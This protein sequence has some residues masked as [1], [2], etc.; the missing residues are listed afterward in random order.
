[1]TR[2]PAL[3]QLL[4]GAKPLVEQETPPVG[5]RGSPDRGQIREGT[6]MLATLPLHNKDS[7]SARRAQSDA[8]RLD[9]WL[10]RGEVER[11]VIETEVTP[12][13]ARLLLQ[14]NA[15]NRL[16]NVPTVENYAAAMR[17]GEWKLNGQNIIIS[18]TGELNDGQTRLHAV[19]D[20][21]MPI[22][23][24]LQFG[25]SRESRATLDT[26][27]KRTLSDHFSMG[28]LHNTNLLAAAVRLAWN[29]D[30][31]AYSFSYSPSVDQ[32]FDYVR[33][34]PAIND[35]LNLS[36]KIA[37]AFKASGAQLAFATF[38][39]ARINQP[40]SRELLNRIGDGLG[41][42]SAG[43]P[44]ARVRERLLQHVS[45]RT[46]LRRNELPAVFIKAFNASLGARRMRAVSWA[47]TGPTG[48]AFPIAGE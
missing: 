29:Y 14:R 25:V 1:M 4:T 44:A 16:L 28:G 19:I 34:N 26:G 35:Y 39:C 3:H 38:V 23:L 8:D 46:P 6:T 2:W 22:P 13:L 36:S 21:D 31:G 48:E 7:G 15:E 18:S 10:R 45:G 9:L 33:R 27:R 43:L 30:L 41:L 47:P 12:E 17:R 37:S 20:A 42:N 32:A 11:F 5:R 40:V 24:G